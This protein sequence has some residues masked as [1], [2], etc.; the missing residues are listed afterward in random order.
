MVN[1]ECSANG[2]DATVRDKSGAMP[3]S[4][5][6]RIRHF[7]GPWHV[8]GQCVTW[9][10]GGGVRSAMAFLFINNG[11]NCVRQL[12]VVCDGRTRAAQ[13]RQ[14]IR[15]TGR[16]CRE[17]PVWRLVG[18]IDARTRTHF[19]YRSPFFDATRGHTVR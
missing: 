13:C 14:P 9:P 2:N 1:I 7:G 11:G 6:T 12:S 19:H 3:R 17:G 18:K 8:S 16:V 4:H 10:A 15:G 5:I